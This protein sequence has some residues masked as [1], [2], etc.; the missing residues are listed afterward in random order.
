[1]D[2]CDNVSFGARTFFIDKA[3]CFSSKQKRVLKSIAENIGE[4]KD[5]LYISTCKYDNNNT[6]DM[7]IIPRRDMR[8]FACVNGQIRH[9][10]IDHNDVQN[11]VEHRTLE[12]FDEIPEKLRWKLFS[13]ELFNRLSE[14]LKYSLSKPLRINAPKE[15]P[16]YVRS[17]LKR[18]A[19]EYSSIKRT[20]HKDNVFD[21][22]RKFMIDTVA[23]YNAAKELKKEQRLKNGPM[24][25]AFLQ[26]E[27]DFVYKPPMDEPGI[28]HKY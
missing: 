11:A 15:D 17:I 18:D 19:K 13:E 6:L 21:K 20:F 26:Y 10:E 28:I 1:M 4:K 24:R 5:F 25:S 8:V 16:K 12:F 2:R 23:D 27:D 14:Y 22:L 7:D 3:G 9:F